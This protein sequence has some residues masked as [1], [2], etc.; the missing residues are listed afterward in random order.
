[1]S[2]ARKIDLLEQVGPALG[3]PDA[4]Q[5]KG[6]RYPNMKELIVQHGGDAIGFRSH[7]IRAG[8]ASFCSA[9]GRPTRSGT[10]LPSLPQIRSMRG[11]WK[12]FAG[13]VSFSEGKMI[14]SL[15]ENVDANELA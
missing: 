7:L 11:T 3:R 6:S 12:K 1:M 5:L 2:I 8:S 14:A 15:E 4:D 9:G 13:R 10:R